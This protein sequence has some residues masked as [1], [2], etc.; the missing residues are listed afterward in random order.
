MRHHPQ[1]DLRVVGA[2]QDRARRRDER[3]ADRATLLGAHRD[4]LQ[5][6]IVRRQP[7]GRRARLVVRRVHAAVARIDRERQRVEI[8]RLELGECPVLEQARR[9]RMF[10]RQILEH[11]LV[12]R[13]AGL[14]AAAGLELELFEQ[15]L[16]ELRATLEIERSAGD[17]E[18]LRLEPGEIGGGPRAHLL[19]HSPVD[20]DPRTLHVEQHRD[21]RAFQFLVEP[22]LVALSEASRKSFTSAAFVTGTFCSPN[23]SLIFS[24]K[25]VSSGV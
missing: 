9:E 24:A 14:G 11:R 1:L 12:G 22:P 21:E 23:V 2:D 18:Q 13:E 25:A 20:R 5:V 8:R 19:E 16:R 10:A 15:D 3:A 17:C 7:P 4:V 6:G